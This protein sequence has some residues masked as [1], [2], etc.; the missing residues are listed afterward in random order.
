MD[1]GLVYRGRIFWGGA[2]IRMDI[3]LVYRGRIFWGLIFG[4]ILG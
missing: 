3:G 1:I 2:Y 4:W